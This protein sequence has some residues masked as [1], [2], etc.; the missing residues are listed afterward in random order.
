ML[1]KIQKHALYIFIGLI[2]GLILYFLNVWQVLTGEP[3]L[4]FL[5]KRGWLD[6]PFWYYTLVIVLGCAVLVL[7][8]SVIKAFCQFVRWKEVRWLED[9][10]HK[11]NTRIKQLVRFDRPNLSVAPHLNAISPYVI[12]H[13]YVFN[14]SIYSL[15][16]EERVGQHFTFEGAP[17]LE[18][19]QIYWIPNM[20]KIIEAK[21]G[22][23]FSFYVIQQIPYSVVDLI[24]SKM[25][26]T[27]GAN[28]V[29]VRFTYHDYTGTLQQVRIDFECQITLEI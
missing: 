21:A 18:Q 8:V 19:A 27:F 6:M 13:V 15:M 11:Q 26:R 9:L 22:Q 10:A 16:L 17:L 29:S 24:Q 4:P 12:F 1:E 3:L 23:Y 5:N 14:G 28:N 7:Q 25:G 20:P 2:G